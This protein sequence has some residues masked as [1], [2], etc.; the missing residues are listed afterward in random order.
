MEKYK[1]GDY[2]FDLPQK[3]L[4]LYKSKDYGIYKDKSGSLPVC[5]IGTNQTTG[6]N[7]G[8]PVLDAYGNFIGINFDRVWEGTM[9]DLYFDP[10][11]CRNVMADARFIM[12]IIEKFSDSDRI[13]KEMKLVKP[14]GK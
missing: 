1:K 10:A 4:D 5:F 3:F 6:G 13:I 8:S 2:E 7:S 14:K 11:I 12:F 9:S